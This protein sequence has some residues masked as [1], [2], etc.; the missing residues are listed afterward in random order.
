MVAAVARNFVVPF[1][2]F[3]MYLRYTSAF[4]GSKRNLSSLK[5][6]SLPGTGRAAFMNCKVSSTLN[7]DA[8][9]YDFLPELPCDQV[10]MLPNCDSHFLHEQKGIFFW[11]VV[12]EI[13]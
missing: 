4:V 10:C 12:K 1:R 2:P 8:A 13:A 6:G 9:L 3:H 7:R 11:L 5:F